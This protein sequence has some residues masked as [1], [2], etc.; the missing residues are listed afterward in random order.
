MKFPRWQSRAVPALIAVNTLIFLVE[1]AA[2]PEFRARAVSLFALTASGL[3]E[4]RWW[5]FVTHAFLH[6]N[7]IHLAVNMV[8]L[9]FAG[10]IVERIL[11]TKRFLVLYFV[12]A[13]AGGLGQIIATGGIRPLI[14]ASGAVCGVLLAFTTMFAETEIVALLFFIIPLRMRAKY[15]GWGIMGSS[16]LFLVIGF[17]PW[18]GHGAH[19][20]GCLAGYLYARLD[21]YGRQTFLERAIRR[22]LHKGRAG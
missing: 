15:L 2:G 18:I 22:L 4:G 14:G 17:E 3:M 7:F 6:G 19:L 10:R 20:G 8:G 1:K 16:L 21:G 13:V 12:S 5:Q 9:W 11:G